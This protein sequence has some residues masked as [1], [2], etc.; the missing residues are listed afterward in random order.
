MLYTN[1]IALVLRQDL[2]SWQKLNVSAFLASAIAIQFP[3]T[4]GQPLV[5][6][7]GTMYLPFLKLPIR[8][9]QADDLVAL[10]RARSRAHERGLALAIYTEPLFATK[11]EAENV[12]VIASYPDDAQLLVGLAVYGDSKLVNKALDGMKLHE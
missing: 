2:P 12:A 9:Y 4:H 5:S 6:A 7:T 10:Q 3:E 11:G 1:K 8:V